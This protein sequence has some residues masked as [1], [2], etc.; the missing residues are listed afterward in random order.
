MKAI[1]M[2][3]ESTTRETFKPAWSSRTPFRPDSTLALS[4]SVAACAV[5]VAP[6]ERTNASLG[7]CIPGVFAMVDSARVA[8]SFTALTSARRKSAA[9][10]NDVDA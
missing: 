5:G 8:A 2:A 10:A 6:T 4:S 3:G 9:S 1:S 7:W